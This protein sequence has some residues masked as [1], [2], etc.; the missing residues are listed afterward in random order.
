LGL[1]R[2]TLAGAQEELGGAI[3]ARVLSDELTQQ[4]ARFV[5]FTA[6]HQELSEVKLGSDEI[7][8]SPHGGPDKDFGHLGLSRAQQLGGLAVEGYS[9]S[10]QLF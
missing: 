4:L 3:V 7:R 10:E 8:V 9:G 2:S 6:Q 5:H 1:W